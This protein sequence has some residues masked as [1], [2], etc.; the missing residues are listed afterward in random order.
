MEVTINGRIGSIRWH[1]DGFLIA[2]LVTGESILGQI[3]TPSPQLNYEFHGKWSTHPKYGLQFLFDSYSSSAPSDPNAVAAY[4]REQCK[5]IGPQV[6]KAISNAYGDNALEICKTNPERVAEE[7]KGITLERA[8]EIQ[9]KLCEIEKDEKTQIAL[10]E[11]F[12]GIPIQKRSIK[13][14]CEEW[15][16]D[17]PAA[18]KADP[19]ILPD[20]I[21]GIGFPIADLVGQKLGIKPDDNRRVRGAVMHCMRESFHNG[22]THQPVDVLIENVTQMTSCERSVIV[23]MIDLSS[24]SEKLV[25]EEDR[26]YLRDSWKA[27]RDI[28]K[29][30]VLMLS[31][32]L[33][34]V[35]AK[36]DGLKE[37]QAEAVKRCLNES[38]S[39][40]TGPA[41]SGKSFAIKKVVNSIMAA[42]AS[43]KLAGVSLAAPTGKAAKRM[44]EHTNYSA[45]T[46]HKLL[47]PELIS[48]KEGKRGGLL[49]KFSRDQENPLEIKCL[50]LDEVSMLDLKLFASVMRAMPPHSRLVLV[51][52]PNQLPAVGAGN[53]LRDLVRSQIIP[54]SRLTS[55]KRQNPGLLLRNAHTVISGGRIKM[56][57]GPQSD[58]F[59]IDM[60]D[61]QLIQNEICNLVSKRLPEYYGYDPMRDIQVI[62][63]FREKTILSCKA[64][65]SR[66]QDRLNPKG[67][68]LGKTVFRTGD[69]VIQKRN[70]YNLEIVNGDIGIILGEE[71]NASKSWFLKVRFENPDREVLIQM[72]DN[73]LH[74]AYCL[75]CHS[76]QGSES[77]AI[78]MPI[79]TSF[80]SLIMQRPWTY[81]AITRAKNLCI[82]VGQERAFHASVRRNREIKRHTSL[83]EKLQEA[84]GTLS[85]GQS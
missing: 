78:V 48:E 82:V 74:L 5:W 63:P 84:V 53:V 13:H 3:S 22:H 52:D 62:S 25:A 19:Y 36:L 29:K 83:A 11:L 77:P 18:I 28:I 4:L 35:P 41:G 31:D 6:S 33:V 44:F 58:F 46:I 61:Q 7:I 69:K 81:T 71:Q 85:G 23:D 37:D 12:L 73:H 17:A 15:G 32:E 76:Y 75:T 65:N 55:I 21:T 24:E 54:V 14:I 51:G 27:E 10:K 2:E 42:S 20:A 26:I 47:E 72:Y 38:V 9:S 45:S 39:I 34:P 30:L 49:F 16:S 57:E 60:A 79:H 64:L 66:L 56:Q 70:D 1:K 8:N 43:S 40:V 59:L 67:R 80:G 68:P 50:V